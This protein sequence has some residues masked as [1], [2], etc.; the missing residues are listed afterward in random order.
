MPTNAASKMKPEIKDL[1]IKALR[2]G[3]R[4]QGYGQ[5]RRNDEHCCLGVLSELG[6]EAGICSRTEVNVVETDDDTGKD[7]EYIEFRYGWHKETAFLPSEIMEWAGLESNNGIFRI[8]NEDGYNY[9]S[10]SLVSLNDSEKF[11]FAQ[12]A[13][14][15]EEHF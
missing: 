8:T 4:K 1:W 6:F 14:Y 11:T 12:I 10:E 5:L 3:K 9:S 2:D 15:V 7:V 13:D